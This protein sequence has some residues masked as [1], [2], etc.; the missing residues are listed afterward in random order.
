MAVAGRLDWDVDRI[1]G[2]N[3]R[4]ASDFIVIFSDR[5]HFGSHPGCFDDAT[6]YPVERL[7]P[8]VTFVGDE[9]TILFETPGIDLRQ[10]AILMYESFDVTLPRNVIRVNGAELP[11]GI[12]VSSRRGEWKSNLSIL[13]PGSI[14]DDR[15]NELF[16]E[17]RG[18]T[19]EPDVNR[20]NF[21]LTSAVVLYK[22]VA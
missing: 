10:P 6:I 15:P 1:F 2:G 9:K 20:D 4:V 19:D 13:E 7:E 17:A 11:G 21:I 3:T 8:G 16:I 18:E 12:P 14:I 5:L 22:T